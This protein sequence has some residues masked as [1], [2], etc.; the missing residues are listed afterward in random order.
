MRT[1]YYTLVAAAALALPGLATAQSPLRL[2]D[3][4]AEADR[5]AFGNRQAAANASS[6]RARAALPLKGILPS[7]RVEGGFVRTTD[8]IGAFG[9]TLRQRAVTP[10]AFDPARLNDPA[11]VNNVTGGLVLEVPV[12]NAD[13]LTGWRAARSAANASAAMADWTTMTTRA[14]VVKAY[15][16]AVLAQE[17]VA[18]LTQAQRAA[19]A[20]VKQVESMVRQG[21]VTKADQLQASVRAGDVAAQLLS[22]SNDATTARQQFAMLLGRSESGPLVLPAGLPTDSV[23]RAFAEQ[24]TAAAHTPAAEGQSAGHLRDDVRAAQLGAQAA[25]AD[26]KRAAATMLPRLNGFARY[27]YNSP[28][29]LYAG[30]PNWTVGVMGSWSLFGGGSELA[31]VAGADARARGARAGEEAAR[32]NA[33]VEADAAA[34]LVTLALRRLEL[35]AQASAQSTEAH[36]LV[37]KRYAGGLAT[38][39]ELLGAETAATGASLAH[40]AARFD[41]IDALAQYRKAIG[42]DPGALARFDTQPTTSSTDAASA[43]ANNEEPTR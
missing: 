28:T 2:A 21:L 33:R 32:A 13:A 31:D 34:R 40:A 4:L 23:V 12:F 39:A 3:A 42:A 25:S 43:G 18:M 19:T 16:G 35:A 36:R 7:A 1:I 26:R 30:K 6:D 10:A 20:A 9:T 24:D 11:P 37:A 22:A 29:T 17:K 38:V 15:Y 41:V 8:P 5:R 14:M 27:D